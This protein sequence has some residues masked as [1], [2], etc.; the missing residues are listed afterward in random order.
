MDSN[1]QFIDMNDFVP[2]LRLRA[3]EAGLVAVIDFGFRPDGSREQPLPETN[4]PG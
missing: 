4:P 2:T 3:T 1:T